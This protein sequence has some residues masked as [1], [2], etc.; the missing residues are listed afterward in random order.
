MS[1]PANDTILQGVPTVSKVTASMFKTSI[2]CNR[3]LYKEGGFQY[4][5][6]F[7]GTIHKEVQ[8]VKEK[9]TVALN[10]KFRPSSYFASEK[11]GED[12]GD[13]TPGANK[14]IDALID[15]G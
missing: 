8:K 13:A 2:P 11:Y 14:A 10:L 9:I 12:E 3:D 15:L 6:N 4:P 5:Q 7:R 1:A